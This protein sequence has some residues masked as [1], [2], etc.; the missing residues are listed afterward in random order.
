MTCCGEKRDL[1]TCCG[2]K[3]LAEE[4]GI[5]LLAG[6][7]GGSGSRGTDPDWALAMTLRLAALRMSLSK[8]LTIWENLGLR[9]RSRTQ[10]SSMSWCSAV[11]QSMGGGS[12]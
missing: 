9:F 11:G 12:R 1:V 5:G 10:Q 7:Q 4:A 2:E 8:V 3:D 6:D